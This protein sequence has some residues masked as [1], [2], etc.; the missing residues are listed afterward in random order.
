ME[1]PDA[2]FSVDGVGSCDGAGTHRQSCSI[3]SCL[4]H[5]RTQGLLIGKGWTGLWRNTLGNTMPW[6]AI[7]LTPLTV[8]GS[9]QR[10]LIPLLQSK[11][12]Q[13]NPCTHLVTTKT[14]N[15]NFRGHGTVDRQTSLLHNGLTD[16][17]FSTH[18]PRMRNQ[19][20]IWGILSPGWHFILFVT[21]LWQFW[22]VKARIVPLEDPLLSVCADAIEGTFGL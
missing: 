11:V 14:A 18:V 1:V 3:M 16:H 19:I 12:L 22:G 21:N 17:Y 5:C 9:K 13:R 6:S 7:V 15:T 4:T 8:E 2:C 10:E 20:G